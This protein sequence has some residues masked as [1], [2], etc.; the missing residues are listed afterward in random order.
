MIKILMLKWE[1]K[2]ELNFIKMKVSYD[3]SKQHCVLSIRKGECGVDVLLL[4]DSNL[5]ADRKE[6]WDPNQP[7]WEHTAMV[8]AAFIMEGGPTMFL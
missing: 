1:S 8:L 3:V 5:G 4:S 6:S 7:W 2:L